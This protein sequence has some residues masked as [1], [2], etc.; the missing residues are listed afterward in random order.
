MN[1]DYKDIRSAADRL[2]HRFQ[3]KVDAPNAPEMQSL[4]KQLRQIVEDIE[5]GHKPRTIEDRI[6]QAQ[7]TL[8]DV[9]GR[10]ST[11]MN[12]GDADELH[13]GYEDL[14]QDVRELPNY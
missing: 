6:K 7:N 4:Q 12:S 2:F 1:A 14:R 3:D 9:Q 13:D 5:S 8:K 10:G 11:F